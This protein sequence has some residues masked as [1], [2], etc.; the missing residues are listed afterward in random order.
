MTDT[1]SPEERS[2]IM[3]HVKSC[4][5][6]PELQVRASLHAAGFRFRL[7]RPDLPGRPDIVLPRYRTVVFVNGCLWH[8]H[9]CRRGRMP[10]THH[11]YWTEKIARNAA[12]DERNRQALLDSGWNV[13]VIW[14]CDMSTGIDSLLRQL[15]ELK[16]RA[17]ASTK[18][19]AGL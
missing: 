19:P 15:R 9:D 6:A 18:H 14:E 7:H 3:S 17:A 12:R 8:G 5:T 11:E 4:N 16:S 13:I 10:A 1:V 2:R